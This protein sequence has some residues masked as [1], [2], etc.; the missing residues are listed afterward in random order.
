VTLR[1]RLYLALGLVALALLVGAVAVVGS[2]RRYLL[3][4]VDRDLDQLRPVLEGPGDRPGPGRPGAGPP[5]GGSSQLSQLFLARLSSDG[6][7]EI[8]LRGD[9]LEAT[10]ALDPDHLA[11]E[12]GRTEHFTTGASAGGGRFRVLAVAVDG[13]GWAVAALPL[14]DTDAAIRRLVVTLALTSAVALGALGLIA[15]WIV[16]L[17]LRPIA[18]VT[19]AA[20]AIAGG[21]RASRVDIDQ[22]ATEAGRLASAFNVMLDE[23]DR[24]EARLRQFVADASHEL[25][26]PLTSIRGYLDLYQQG[27]FRGA[28]ELDDVVRRMRAESSRM[29]GL[30]EDLLTLAHLD[31]GRPLARGPVDLAEVVGDA[32]ADARAVQP[33]RMVLTEVVADSALVVTGDDARLRQVVA[34]LVDNALTH[35]PPAVAITLRARHAPGAVVV[36]VA[37]TGPGMAPEVAARVFDRFYRH[38]A[39]RSRARG[40][41]GLGLAI[42]KGIAEAHGGTLAVS[43][44][45]G[46]GATF[47]LQL[48][49]D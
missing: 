32:A 27:G 17:G 5:L 7:V 10:P 1:R 4:Q 30:V 28:G 18:A 23:R 42:A 2:Q 3:D 8:A 41:S 34:A 36:E 37:D 20:D 14:E 26:T 31:E 47:T 25:R 21:Q 16:R 13:G 24:G 49:A 45:P 29:H 35:T 48:P 12:P 43:S 46:A 44:T 9:L 40:G 22:P 19:A 11:A 39:A 38:D 33:E 6:T 15:W